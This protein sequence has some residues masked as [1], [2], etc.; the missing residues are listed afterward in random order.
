MFP[1]WISQI[2]HHSPADSAPRGRGGW[3]SPALP[4]P[5]SF[6]TLCS[7][8]DQQ[9]KGRSFGQ[10]HQELSCH[11]GD[12]EILGSR[13]AGK[14]KMYSLC[15][16][17]FHLC[18]VPFYCRSD[19][20]QPILTR[21]PFWSGKDNEFPEVIP[22]ANPSGALGAMLCPW[23]TLRAALG[24]RALVS[25]IDFV[26]T[27]LVSP[28]S[29]HKDLPRKSLSLWPFPFA[30][31]ATVPHP[32][33]ILMGKATPGFVPRLPLWGRYWGRHWGSPGCPRA[34]TAITPGLLSF[35]AE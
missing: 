30:R 32:S 8:W 18:F 27:V 11:Q 13:E 21:F 10:Q 9:G 2:L 26:F 25:T 16:Q 1:K 31:G 6:W 33:Q 35:S 5:S 29:A 34:L 24:V 4:C 15:K 17:I 23:D 12:P 3:T 22:V 14:A 19:L 20:G 28:S 7:V